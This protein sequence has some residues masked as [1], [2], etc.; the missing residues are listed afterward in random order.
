MDERHP[1]E[2]ENYYGFT[3]LEIE[4]ILAWYDRLK[5]L[6]YAALRYFNAAGYDCSGRVRGLERNPANLI[7]RVMEVASGLKPSLQVYGDDY[8]TPDGTCV[9]DY[10]HVDDLA[11]GHLAAL[12][13]ISRNDKSLVVNLGSETGL[14]VLEILEAA[15]RVTGKS[16]PA[17]V[18]GRR[19]GDPAR[20]CA[21]SSLAR[22]L[23]GWK[24]EVSDPETLVRTT[25]AA[26]SGR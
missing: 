13:W 4:R 12:E 8:D 2:P 6:R 9:R 10:V 22:E 7:P 25:W 20:I 26:Y 24:A 19:P 14:S 21:S 16:I 3:K 1:T 23:L 15:R 18:V 11:R 5:G 17:Q